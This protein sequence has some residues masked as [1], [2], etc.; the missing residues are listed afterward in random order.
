MGR[1]A[2]FMAAVMATLA[3]FKPAVLKSTGQSI[4]SSISDSISA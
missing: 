3:V 1:F 2:I 4:Q